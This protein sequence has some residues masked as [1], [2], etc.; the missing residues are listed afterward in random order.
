MDVARPDFRVVGEVRMVHV[1]ADGALH[2]DLFVQD[3]SKS[4]VRK[5]VPVYYC[6][7]TCERI[8]ASCMYL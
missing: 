5:G 4:A 8:F 3:F 6:S 2:R 1:D 7:Q